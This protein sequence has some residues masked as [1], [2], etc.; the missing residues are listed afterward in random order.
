MYA[1]DLALKRFSAPGRYLLCH[2]ERLGDELSDA[3]VLATGRYRNR[4]SDG[5][6]V[7]PIALLA[8]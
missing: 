7:I 5:I 3:V 2:G 6:G 1:N 4:R 8:P